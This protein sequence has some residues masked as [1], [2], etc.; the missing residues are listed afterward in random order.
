MNLI[1]ALTTSATSL[2]SAASHYLKAAGTTLVESAHG[3]A[4]AATSR[5]KAA[6]NTLVETVQAVQGVANSAINSVGAAGASVQGL[7]QRV[8]ARLIGDPTMESP[9]HDEESIN[10]AVYEGLDNDESSLYDSLND[11]AKAIDMGFIETPEEATARIKQAQ[12]ARARLIKSLSEK[13]TPTSKV[14]KA[15]PS[16]M[17]AGKV[18][19]V[20]LSP[21]LLILGAIGLLAIFLIAGPEEMRKMY[22]KAKHNI[23][24]VAVHMVA[25]EKVLSNLLDQ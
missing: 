17:T 12:L 4:N 22:Q 16:K 3:L 14:K 7:C 20:A 25:P 19:L 9:I 8:S 18:A 1:T 21:I 10:N 2:P 13:T 23:V 24:A 15:A 6:G 11:A 5:A